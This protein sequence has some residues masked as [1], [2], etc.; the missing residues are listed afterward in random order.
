MPLVLQQGPINLTEAAIRVPWSEIDQALRVQTRAAGFVLD[1]RGL[2]H[3]EDGHTNP[4]LSE[5]VYVIVQGYGVLRCGDMAMECTK[6]DVLFVP[7]GHPHH[8]ER[9]DGQIKIW[10][11]SL[12]P[13]AASN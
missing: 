13:A 3:A 6:D 2:E 8:F 9:L 10:R 1:I 4:S 11:V 7:S 12:V 5:T